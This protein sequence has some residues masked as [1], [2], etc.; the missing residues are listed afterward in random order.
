M[1]LDALNIGASPSNKETQDTRVIPSPF[2]SLEGES[3]D[4]RYLNRYSAFHLLV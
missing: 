4:I 2:N 1:L 3:N